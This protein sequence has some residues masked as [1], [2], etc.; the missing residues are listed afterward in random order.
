MLKRGKIDN[1][2]YISKFR[3]TV[4]GEYSLGGGGKVNIEKSERARV[5]KSQRNSSEGEADRKD[6]CAI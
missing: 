4:E 2:P 5:K 1:Q 6:G 3:H